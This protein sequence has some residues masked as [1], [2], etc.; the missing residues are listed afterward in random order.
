VDRQRRRDRRESSDPFGSRRHHRGRSARLP[1]KTARLLAKA[2]KA[3]ARNAIHVAEGLVRRIGERTDSFPI[4]GYLPDM[5]NCI[6]AMGFG[7][8]GRFTT[9]S[10]PK[11]FRRF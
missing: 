2:K 8:S 5:P 7:G 3:L 10:H 9:K 4:I 11:S 6:T 1:K